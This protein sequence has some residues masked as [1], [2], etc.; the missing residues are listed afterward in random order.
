MVPAAS[1]DIPVPI[2]F[3]FAMYLER[4]NCAA[5]WEPLDYYAPIK[6]N[7]VETLNDT[8]IEHRGWSLAKNDGYAMTLWSTNDCSGDPLAELGMKDESRYCK[9]LPSLVKGM[10]IRP[11]FNADYDLSFADGKPPGYWKKCGPNEC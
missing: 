11:L 10:S 4:S 1:S 6:C 8:G 3:Q 7:P 9:S 5:P 2:F